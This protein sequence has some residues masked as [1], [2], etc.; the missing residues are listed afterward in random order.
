MVLTIRANEIDA[1]TP[2]AKS[3]KK[4]A[5]RKNVTEAGSKETRRS[6]RDEEQRKI[7]IRSVEA[8]WLEEPLIKPDGSEKVRNKAQKKLAKRIAEKYE[9]EGVTI[10]KEAEK[11]ERKVF[12]GSIAHISKYLG[13]KLL[14]KPGTSAPMGKIRK[15]CV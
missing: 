9:N 7:Y 10:R 6:F 3:R 2:K 8:Y 1:R 11:E 4:N 12:C 5:K 14:I 13:E 15:F